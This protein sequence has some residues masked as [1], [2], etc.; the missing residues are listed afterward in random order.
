V[1]P[2]G[3]DTCVALCIMSK[4]R[5]DSLES[6]WKDEI[7]EHCT[8]FAKKELCSPVIEHHLEHDLNKLMDYAKQ[9]WLMNSSCYLDVECAAY[10]TD[11]AAFAALL[12]LLRLK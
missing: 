9:S 3:P 2:A 8:W 4:Q 10:M 7:D 11:N 1:T 12:F 5:L 6:K